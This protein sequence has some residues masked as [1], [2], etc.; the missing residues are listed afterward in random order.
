MKKTSSFQHLNPNAQ[1]AKVLSDV[2]F[3]CTTLEQECTPSDILC[4]VMTINN[5]EEEEVGGSVHLSLF[6]LTNCAAL[7][8]N[9]HGA[10][11]AETVLR[12][13]KQLMDTIHRGEWDAEP[14]IEH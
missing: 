4:H 1:R 8:T 12:G 2:L 10:I 14:A 13:N 7:E 6:A 5:A 11:S 3:Y 9:T